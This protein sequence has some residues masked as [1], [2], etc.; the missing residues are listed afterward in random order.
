MILTFQTGLW[1]WV[2]F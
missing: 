2:K 1:G